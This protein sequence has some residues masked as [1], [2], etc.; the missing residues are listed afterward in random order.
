MEG[1]TIQITLP[2]PVAHLLEI[3][4]AK[5]GIKLSEGIARLLTHV[6]IQYEKKKGNA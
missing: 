6:V 1:T 3:H 4:A 2:Q 5:D